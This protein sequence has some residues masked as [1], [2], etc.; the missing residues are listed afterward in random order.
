MI[1]VKQRSIDLVSNGRLTRQAPRSGGALTLSTLQRFVPGDWLRI[2]DGT[3]DLNAAI[4]LT[5]TQTMTLG[6]GV[7]TVRLAGGATPSDAASIYTGRGRLILRG[8]TVS[9]FDPATGQ[10]MPPGPGRPFIVVSRGARF[11]A[12]DSAINDLG[13]VPTEPT[14]RA[15]LGLGET[16]TGSLTRTTLARNSIGLKL[17]RTDGVRLEDVTISESVSDGLVLR[18]DRGTVLSKITTNGNG[19]NGVLVVGP[20]SDRPITGISAVSNKLF[21]VAVTGQTR[22][23]VNAVSTA[24]NV[25]GG[26]R[27]SWSTEVTVNDLTSTNDAMGVYTHVG[28]SQTVDQPGPD[29]WPAP[30]L[31]DREDHPRS[32]GERQH[33]RRRVRRRDRHRRS[34]RHPEPGRHR[35]LRHRHARGTRRR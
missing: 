29:Q 4:V 17:D 26:V 30:R 11:E 2:A 33:H 27:V 6:G 32:D 25:V 28:S 1:I 21:G 10:A 20:S 31:A 12:V 3:A 7:R 13:N 8:V 22:P 9:S 34:A 24:N 5:P 23:Q 18:G 16:S 19:G 35:R 14:A 15:G